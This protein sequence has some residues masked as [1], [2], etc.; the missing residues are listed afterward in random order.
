MPTIARRYRLVSQAGS[1]GMAEVWQAL[2]TR[3]DRTVAVKELLPE[4][5][6]S[7]RARERAVAEAR[8]AA[9][10]NHPNVAAVYDAG[11]RPRGVTRRV[12]YLVMEYVDGE[13][14]DRRLRGPSSM[15][16]REAA[17]IVAQVADG[18]AAA[19]LHRV[20]HHDVKPGN[21]MLTA[22]QVK[23]V[24]FGLASILSAV[25]G[26]RTGGLVG[27][28]EYM[29]PEQ[30]RGEPVTAATDV[31]ALG[32][33]LYQM[34]TGALPWTEASRHAL[35]R[36]RRACTAV[37]LPPMAEVPAEIVGAVDACLADDPDARPSARRLAA[38]MRAAM[39]RHGDGVEA[40][41]PAPPPPVRE[42][43]PERP[44]HPCTVPWR[45]APS[46][47]RPRRALLVAAVAL[48]AA[49][50]WARPMWS[51]PAATASGPQHDARSRCAVRYVGH[52]TPTTFTADVSITGAAGRPWT[53][54]FTAPS[55]QRVTRVQGAGWTQSGSLI[56]V[57]G[58]GPLITAEPA[59]VELGGV[60]DRP[61]AGFPTA[62]ELDGSPCQR[63]VSIYAVG[64]P[65]EAG[66]P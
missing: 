47:R 7:A 23:I 3:L 18:L 59:R 64:A 45:T 63:T 38:V 35:V 33:V 58:Q 36:Q 29:A 56:T 19:H 12:P 57:T 54:R 20:V 66:E 49:A 8:A 39:G 27:T 25:P 55:G 4:L 2:D 14:L 37:R 51:T 61:D 43:R 32:L 62:F 22:S 34:L 31:Y 40:S 1:G 65:A 17:W 16:W 6:G 11:H 21:I 48:V 42:Q 26:G 52:R 44:R 24:D 15:P 41:A 53:L 5:A 10:I 30:L 60:L 50:G 28:P 13:T 9:R 46:R